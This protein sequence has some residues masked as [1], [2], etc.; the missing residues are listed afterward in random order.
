[1]FPL[2]VHFPVHNK[3]TKRRPL[4]P[5]A[6]QPSSRPTTPCYSIPR[7]SPQAKHVIDLGLQHRIHCRTRR[8]SHHHQRNREEQRDRPHT[9]RS[10][11]PHRGRP[12]LTRS[13]KTT[14]PAS[15]TRRFSTKPSPQIL[16]QPFRT[17]HNPRSQA[18]TIPDRDCTARSTQHA[19]AEFRKTPQ[20]AA[21]QQYPQAH[22]Q[23]IAQHQTC[24]EPATQEHDLR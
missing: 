19:Q 12:H 1:M 8:T 6:L 14:N 4:L 17:D 18:K 7:I 5:N 15:S 20:D 22:S 13:T 9:I 16:D 11:P 23:A 10:P 3:R 21:R 24:H 2:P